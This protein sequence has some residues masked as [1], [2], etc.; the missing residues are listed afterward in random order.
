[1][2]MN[3]VENREK[4]RRREDLCNKFPNINYVKWQQCESLFAFYFLDE[5]DD[6]CENFNNI[7][8]HHTHTMSFIYIV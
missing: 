8:I 5:N 7:Y 6:L 4:L 3:L 2:K 1:M